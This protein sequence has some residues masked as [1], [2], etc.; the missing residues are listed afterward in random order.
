MSEQKRL[1]PLSCVDVIEIDDDGYATEESMRKFREIEFDLR[2]ADFFLVHEF[3]DIMEHMPCA[4]IET[5]ETKDI[6]GKDA[7]RIIAQDICRAPAKR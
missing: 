7:L 1:D 6:M 2:V 4:R 5:E 3:T